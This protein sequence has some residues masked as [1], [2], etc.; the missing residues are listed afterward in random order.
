MLAWLSFVLVILEALKII[1]IG[2]MWCIVPF[3]A[4]VVLQLTVLVGIFVVGI[5]GMWFSK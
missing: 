3:L 2:Y 1:H 5:V 4:Q